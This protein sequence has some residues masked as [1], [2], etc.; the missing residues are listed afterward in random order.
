MNR[1]S[2]RITSQD[3]FDGSK[4]TGQGQEAVQFEHTAE[5]LDPSPTLYMSTSGNHLIWTQESLQRQR[6]NILTSYDGNS[7]YAGCRH[8]SPQ[9]SATHPVNS[10]ATASTATNSDVTQTEKSSQPTGWP[11]R[12]PSTRLSPQFVKTCCRPLP[13]RD[14][15]HT[16]EDNSPSS[17]P[18]VFSTWFYVQRGVISLYITVFQAAQQESPRRLRPIRVA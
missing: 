6:A 15:R 7:L 13:A 10:F 14:I 9:W 4:C 1:C 16:V 11:P 17:L 3:S 8:D 2:S 18:V 12:R 5:R